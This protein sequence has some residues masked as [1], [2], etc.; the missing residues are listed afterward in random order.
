MIEPNDALDLITYF[1]KKKF[2]D[3]N[4][5]EIEAFEGN[6]TQLN[7]PVEFYEVVQ[8]LRRLNNNWAVGP[9]GTL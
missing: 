1:F 5:Q 8:S 9:D 2:V 4:T 7:K 6:A 3:E